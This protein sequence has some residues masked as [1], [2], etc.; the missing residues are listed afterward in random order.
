LFENGLFIDLGRERKQSDM[1][2]P[3]DGRGQLT[4][5][6]GASA[7]DSSRHDF[8]SIGN[9]PTQEA[10]VLVIYLDD[11][12]FTELAYFPSHI[13]ISPQKGKSSSVSAGGSLD[14]DLAAPPSSSWVRSDHSRN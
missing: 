9:K 8:T 2:R 13:S 11:L 12:L 14:P 1:A 6:F 3:L 4:L 7:G 10:L 5:V